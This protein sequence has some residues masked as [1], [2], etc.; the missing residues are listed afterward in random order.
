MAR[1][2]TRTR[3]AKEAAIGSPIV[4][5][6]R[7]LQ[8]RSPL[9]EALRE[10]ILTPPSNAPEVTV[11][12]RTARRTL[13]ERFEQNRED[14]LQRGIAMALQRSVGSD[15]TAQTERNRREAQ[16]LLAAAD[17]FTAAGSPL[18]IALAGGATAAGQL[19]GAMQDP[20]SYLAPGRTILGRA[21]GAGAIGAG[22]DVGAQAL[23]IGSDVQDRYSP[24]QTA[25]SMVAPMALSLGG[26]ALAAGL[27]RPAPPP[28]MQ[29]VRPAARRPSPF[30]YQATEAASPQPRAMEMPSQIPEAAT[31]EDAASQVAALRAERARLDQDIAQVSTARTERP[32]ALTRLLD[33]RA[34]ID[35][36][37]AVATERMTALRPAP[38]ERE[39]APGTSEAARAYLDRLGLGDLYELGS[40]RAGPD[41][42]PPDM[43][44]MQRGQRPPGD[45]NAQTQ[46]LLGAIEE[47]AGAAGLGPRPGQPTF[48]TGAPATPEQLARARAARGRPQAPPPMEPVQPTPPQRRAKASGWIRHKKS[49]AG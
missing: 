26:D 32:T 39:P 33:E 27:R 49:P 17:P 42:T 35:R 13:G 2:K 29:P 5:A 1:P 10:P 45:I 47:Q 37:L 28:Q 46:T 23:D 18:E 43:Q 12:P 24:A 31:Y 30:D 38:M 34:V 22:T 9:E 41:L 16:D 7:S 40:T 19:A 3:S 44:P 21:L 36:D 20:T 8:R 4:E 15:L 6:I 14:A 48:R 11:G 25:V